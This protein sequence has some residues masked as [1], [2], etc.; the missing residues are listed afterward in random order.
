MCG[1]LGC[2]FLLSTWASV[3]DVRLGIHLCRPLRHP[4][5][6]SVGTIRLCCPLVPSIYAV[7]RNVYS[8]HLHRRVFLL[9]AQGFVYALRLESV[10]VIRLGVYSCLWL[11]VCS[12]RL[13]G[14]LFVSSALAF[15]S[16]VHLGV[17]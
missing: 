12:C 3:L 17:R 4:F 1:S 8:C 9:F 11:G 13:R 15:I 14:C 16:A 5:V 2:P 6:L 10:R 7:R